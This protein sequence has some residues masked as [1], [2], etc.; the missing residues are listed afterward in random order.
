MSGCDLSDLGRKCFEQSVVD[1]YLHIAAECSRYLSVVAED[2]AAGCDVRVRESSSLRVMAESLYQSDGE[3]EADD[4][5]K[6]HER[7][8]PYRTALERRAVRLGWFR[9]PPGRAIGRWSVVA[10]LELVAG[11]LIGIIG[12]VVPISGLL[13]VA[14]GLGIGALG[15]F[16]F[17]QAMPQRTPNGARIDGMLKAYRRTLK[18]TMEQARSMD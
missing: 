13:F 9:E 8:G 11:V 4:L 15:T 7:I 6:L 16:G 18:L 14:G 17:A 5:A 1:R 2:R 3:I 12:V 10:V